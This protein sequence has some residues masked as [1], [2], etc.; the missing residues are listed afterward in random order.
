MS[1][2]KKVFFLIFFLIFFIVRSQYQND[3]IKFEKY[4]GILCD[5]LYTPEYSRNV[6]PKNRFKPNLY[7]AE[8]FEKQFLSQYGIA[9]KKHHDLFYEMFIHN[10][11]I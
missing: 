4:L 7:D 3:T 8:K 9:I 6:F 2:I 1:F 11:V 10:E 5:S